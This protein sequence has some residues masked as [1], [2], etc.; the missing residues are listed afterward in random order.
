VTDPMTSAVVAI[1]VVTLLL[2]GLAL[3]FA[4][5]LRFLFSRGTHRPDA[6]PDGP[7]QPTD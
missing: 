3:L 4:V 2:P 5:V 1:L 7:D 6:P